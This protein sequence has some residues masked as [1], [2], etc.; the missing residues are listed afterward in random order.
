MLSVC[1]RGR[2]LDFHPRWMNRKR[3]P[4]RE[5]SKIFAKSL[6]GAILCQGGVVLQMRSPGWHAM[7][8]VEQWISPLESRLQVEQPSFHSPQVGFSAPK[9]RSDFCSCRA[10]SADAGSAPGLASSADAS[11]VNRAKN[12]PATR[13][14]RER[15]D[16]ILGASRAPPCLASVRNA[17]P[18][19]GARR[20]SR[21]PRRSR[22]PAPC[23]RSRPA[24]SPSRP[25]HRGPARRS[26]Y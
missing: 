16:S 1:P 11:V 18:W 8:G 23:R 10:G 6:L 24:R 13:R 22:A 7:P 26:R 15:R 9:S 25:V 2:C 12:A 14:I 3:S 21:P 17:V 20:G 5:V 4:Q 19:P